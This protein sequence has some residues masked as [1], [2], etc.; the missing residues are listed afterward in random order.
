MGSKRFYPE[1]GPVHEAYVAGFWMD[2]TPITNNQFRRFV[3]ATGYVTIAERVPNPED[4]PDALPELLVPGSAVFRQT[5]GPVDLR[6]PSWWHYV[7]GADW[8][9][10]IPRKVLEGGSYLCAPNYCLRYRPAA[11]HPETIDTSTSHIGFRCI[12]RGDA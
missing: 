2:A 7:P 10:R 6:V 1:E 8:R 5:R 9:I 3:K 4:Y 11:R 12:A